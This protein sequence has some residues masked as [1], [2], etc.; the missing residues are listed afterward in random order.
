L[1]LPP[2]ILK[3]KTKNKYFLPWENGTMKGTH[4]YVLG[5]Y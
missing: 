3:K 2:C 4:Y 1:T 5:T